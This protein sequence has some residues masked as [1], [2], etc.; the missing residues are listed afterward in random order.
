MMKSDSS[1]QADP[2]NQIEQSSWG[3]LPE[4]VLLQIFHLL[5]CKELGRIAQTCWRWKS[6]SET[7]LLWK[8][9]F[10][11]DY[12]LD[13]DVKLMPEAK[14]WR[15]EYERLS[16]R[17]PSQELDKIEEHTDEVLHVAFSHNGM[18]F[19]T[20]SKDAY[21]KVYNADWPFETV[22]SSRLGGTN[23]L[24]QW[25]YTQLS[26]FSP[27][28]TQLLV[29]GRC[30]G[31][32]QGGE[33]VIYNIFAGTFTIQSRV[34]IVP[35]DVM[36]T[37]LN[38]SHILSARAH[39]ITSSL[40]CL[41]EVVLNKSGQEVEYLYQST[42]TRS[43]LFR[44]NN[45][46][47]VSY[48]L[49]SDL[50]KPIRQEI[51]NNYTSD[52]TSVIHAMHIKNLQQDLHKDASKT[53]LNKGLLCDG[54]S[55]KGFTN[56]NVK[57][58]KWSSATSL[59]AKSN[60]FS[61]CSKTKEDDSD[62]EQ[63]EL[64]ETNG[65]L[66][67]CGMN[68][69]TNSLQFIEHEPSQLRAEHL[70]QDVVDHTQEVELPVLYCEKCGK[71][72]N[73]LFSR[74]KH[75]QIFS[76]IDSS[77]ATSADDDFAGVQL[78]KRYK[79]LICF[80]G[81]LVCFPHQIG[82]KMLKQEECSKLADADLGNL[83]S[84]ND[85]NRSALDADTW[86]HVLE[87]NGQCVGMTLSPCN[88]YLY[89]NVREWIGSWEAILQ[90]NNRAPLE[91]PQISTMI[92]MVVFDLITM[93]KVS[94]ML[95]HSAVSDVFFLHLSTNDLYVASGSEDSRGYIWDRHYNTSVSSLPHDDVVNCVAVNPR[96]PSMAVSVSDDKT[97]KIWR[98][99][100]FHRLLNGARAK[101]RNKLRHTSHHLST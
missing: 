84:G 57:R 71:K 16:D 34:R 39:I 41:C 82:I 101:A 4:D 38:E 55:N 56:Q 54:C 67:S 33:I 83:L 92:K 95:G 13:S 47:T 66:K 96:D 63:S 3:F 30:A 52:L 43:F 51:R 61:F 81:Q 79:L 53:D 21:I 89:V 70:H 65:L 72:V 60:C 90:Q 50:S 45:F 64:H 48:L 77:S 44:C 11:A 22:F 46:A 100:A 35:Y 36:G 76:D 93:K 59:P 58:P 12:K 25:K 17:A 99:K 24:F 49:V 26:Q 10:I 85:H 69:E 73:S 18:M 1:N 97:I 86:D 28:D 87:M 27:S 23:S 9:R 40:Q 32:N 80:T 74:Q 42:V 31:S 20:C 98:S 19:S 88:R 94:T 78:P 2:Q 68:T 62:V 37:W 29:S 8:R 7:E 14:S 6:I 5:T 75:S 15:A 91:S